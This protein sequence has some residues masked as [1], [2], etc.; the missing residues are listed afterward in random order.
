MC[1]SLTMCRQEAAAQNDTPRDLLARLAAF[2]LTM[3]PPRHGLLRREIPAAYDAGVG[4]PSITRDMTR[5]ELLAEIRRHG[6]RSHEAVGGN[7][8]LLRRRRADA[9]WVDITDLQRPEI[10]V[11]EIKVT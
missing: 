9:V 11:H 7:T 2:Y 1:H 5:D 8:E 4:R 3:V 6:Q 10:E